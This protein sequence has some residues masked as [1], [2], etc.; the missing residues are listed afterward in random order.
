MSEKLAIHVVFH[1][2]DC[3][4]HGTTAT[5]LETPRLI[6]NISRRD[7]FPRMHRDAMHPPSIP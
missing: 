1:W 2:R 7:R 5:R 4:H 3:M 6:R